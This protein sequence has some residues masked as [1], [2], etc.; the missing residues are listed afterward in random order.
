[1]FL[2]SE[3]TDPLRSGLGDTSDRVIFPEERKERKEER[4][5]C[6]AKVESLDGASWAEAVNGD[7]TPSLPGQCD[8]KVSSICARPGGTHIYGSS[9]CGLAASWVVR[10][11]RYSPFQGAQ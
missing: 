1:M 3:V 4:V 7:V 10:R 11:T 9:P 8:L 6:L 5:S 2:S